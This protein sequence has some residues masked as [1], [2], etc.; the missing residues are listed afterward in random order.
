M[1]QRKSMTK[2]RKDWILPLKAAVLFSVLGEREFILTDRSKP[3]CF[4]FL[5]ESRVFCFL[6]N[7]SDAPVCFFLYFVK[8]CDQ[9]H[10]FAYR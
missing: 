6:V 5:S 8:S 10:V 7:G 3:Y 1:I 2:K 9:L 4:P